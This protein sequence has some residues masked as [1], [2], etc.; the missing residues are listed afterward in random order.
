MKGAYLS[1]TYISEIPY[2]NFGQLW[3]KT[4]YMHN[5]RVQARFVYWELVNIIFAGEWTP[6]SK[7]INVD[8]LL[9]YQSFEK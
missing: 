2:H 9:Q 8:E 3:L 4:A 7:S 6:V 1:Q 5:F